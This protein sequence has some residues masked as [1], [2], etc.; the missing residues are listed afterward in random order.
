MSRKKHVALSHQKPDG[1]FGALPGQ[2]PAGAD[3]RLEAGRRC[4][5]GDAPLKRQ[6]DVESHNHG[7]S[8][9]RAISMSLWARDVGSSIGMSIGKVTQEGLWKEEGSCRRRGRHRGSCAPL[10]LLCSS[11]TSERWFGSAAGTFFDSSTHGKH[12]GQRGR[13]LH[14]QRASPCGAV[15]LIDLFCVVLRTT[16]A[17]TVGNVDGLSARCELTDGGDVVAASAALFFLSCVV[18]RAARVSGAMLRA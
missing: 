5:S 13:P 11:T 12:L 14:V 1:T 16:T 2:K 18:R 10:R 17:S 7:Q 4:T 6:S 15:G 9:A 3:V 8:L